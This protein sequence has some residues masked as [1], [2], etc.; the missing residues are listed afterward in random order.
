MFLLLVNCL[1]MITDIWETCFLVCRRSWCH[2]ERM[3]PQRW[4]PLTRI[5]FPSFWD[6]PLSFVGV[7]YRTSVL[8][9][10]PLSPKFFW[11]GVFSLLLHV[12]NKASYLVVP[13]LSSTLC[14]LAQ[15]VKNLPAVAGDLGFI[16]ELGRSPGG[17]HGNPLHYSCLE[18]LMDRGAGWAIVR[19]VT[20]SQT[21]PSD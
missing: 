6:Q 8:W 7:L 14:K 4:R 9:N 12:P 16:P 11:V 15:R 13:Y 2:W 1:Q 21:R 17:G 10:F 20:K 19:A 3:Q 5:Q 18:N